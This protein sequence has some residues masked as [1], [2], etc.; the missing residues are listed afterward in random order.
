[1]V[2]YEVVVG[3]VL[4]VELLLHLVVYCGIDV[5]DVLKCG[6]FVLI[7]ALLVVLVLQ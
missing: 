5:I 4:L 7:I 6:V 1:M 2:I 3:A